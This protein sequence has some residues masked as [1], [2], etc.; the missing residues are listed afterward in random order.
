MKQEEFKCNM[1]RLINEHVYMYYY[2]ISS[3]ISCCTLP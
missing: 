1:R 3:P 2:S